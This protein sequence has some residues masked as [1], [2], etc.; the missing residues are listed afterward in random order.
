MSQSNKG[1]TDRN[2]EQ[3]TSR[4]REIKDRID[5]PSLVDKIKSRSSSNVVKSMKCKIVPLP[6]KLSLAHSKV[7]LNLPSSLTVDETF[8]PQTI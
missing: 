5:M 7:K 1:F 6:T 4:F 2:E 8:A 3:L